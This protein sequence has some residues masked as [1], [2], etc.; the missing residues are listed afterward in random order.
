MTLTRDDFAA[1]RRGLAELPRLAYY[2]AGQPIDPEGIFFPTS[3]AK[4]LDPDVALVVG[5]RGVGKSYWAGALAQNDARERV[6]QAYRRQLKLDGLTVRFGFAD[7]EG[8]GDALVSRSVLESAPVQTPPAQIWRAVVLRYLASII[9]AEIPD[10]FA[11]LI[12]WINANPEKQQKIFR[13]ADAYLQESGQ[14]ALLLFDQLDQ[15]AEEWTRINELTMG[16]LQIALAIQSYKSIKIK[17]FMRVD[18]YEYKELFRFQDASKIRGAAVRL[19]WRYSELFS[20]LFLELERNRTSADVFQ[21]CCKISGVMFELGQESS[22]LPLELVASEA[23]QK[24]VFEV[25]AGTA[26]GGGKKR[27]EPYS[28]LPVHLSDSHNEVSPRTFLYCLRSAA[29]SPLIPEASA[30]DYKDIIN[31]VRDASRQRLTELEEE[32]PWVSAVLEPLRGVHVPALREEFTS[33]WEAGSTIREIFWNADSNRLWRSFF[34]GPSMVGRTEEE[35]LLNLLHEIG[36]IDV[37][38]NGKIDVPDIFRVRA[39]IL[40]RGGVPPQQRRLL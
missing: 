2:A 40:R 24:K 23:R 38:K 35:A 18:Q 19:Q 25:I 37:R 36:V 29:Q 32:Y 3:H 11:E 20:L 17:I 10:G 33:R 22:A 4:A 34:E 1:L 9:K 14:T 31:G 39:G 15:L 12:V 27:G 13:D 5:N 16:L 6:A 30:I 28:W 21:E 8:G 7:A 26:M